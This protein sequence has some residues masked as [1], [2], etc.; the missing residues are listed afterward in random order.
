MMDVA[1]TP[2]VER[3]PAK[4]PGRLKASAAKRSAPRRVSRLTA[5]QH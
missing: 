4:A 2:A 1:V 3:P 5:R